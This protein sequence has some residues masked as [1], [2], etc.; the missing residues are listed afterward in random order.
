MFA[1]LATFPHAWYYLIQYLGF[2]MEAYL[3][4]YRGFIQAASSCTSHNPANDWGRNE[5]RGKNSSSK[6][7]SLL[8][9]WIK[10]QYELSGGVN[11]PRKKSENNKCG[12]I[13]KE[14]KN[15]EI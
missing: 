3:I 1:L 5:G 15:A 9:K 6:N 8:M 2:V 12:I 14:I 4:R 11:M 13:I 10:N 7:S